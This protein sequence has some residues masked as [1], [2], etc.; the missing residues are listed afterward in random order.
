MG[1]RPSLAQVAA[2]SGVSVKTASRALSGEGYVAVETKARV[3]SAADELGYRLNRTAR[4]LRRGGN[5]STLVGLL[6][7]DL[8]NPF[9]SRLAS[10]LEREL[11][12][13]GLQLITASTDENPE[14]EGRLTDS[15]LERRVRGLVVASTMAEHGHLA[16]ERRHGS[17]FVFVDRPPVNLTADAVLLDNRGGAKRAAEHLLERGHRRIGIVGDLSRLSTHQDRVEGFAEAMEAAGIADWREYLL[18]DAHDVDKAERAVLALL[19]RDPAPTAVFTTNNRITTGALRA[20]R[21]G[22]GGRDTALIGFDELDLGDV[23]GVTVIAH[24]PEEM[25]RHAARLLLS[26]L[27]GD[28]GPARRVVLPTRLVERSTT[29]PR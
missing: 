4:E 12:M 25:G 22:G 13:H 9:Y 14:W 5:T 28:E 6:S 15:L 17:P 10:G 27:D 8:A 19:A 29:A 24:D 16:A 26:R 18:E 21:Q 7:G 11:R 20:L 2:L 1:S 23:L 3:Q